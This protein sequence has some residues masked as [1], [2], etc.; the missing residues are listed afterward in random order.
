M[1]TSVLFVS[2]DNVLLGAT[3]SLLDLAVGL[4]QQGIEV[5]VVFPARGPASVR[6]KELGVT[7]DIVP[8][9]T[10]VTYYQ[11]L[12]IVY[13][14]IRRLK[15]RR[16]YKQLA[17]YISS[18]H[19]KFIYLNTQTLY[20]LLPFID[21][22]RTLILHIR[23]FG[24]ADHRM[25]YLHSGAY[26]KKCLHRA[27]ILLFNSNA[28]KDALVSQY[29]VAGKVV[30][31]GVMTVAEMEHALIDYHNALKERAAVNSLTIGV[32]GALNP[33]KGQEVVI[34]AVK[35]LYDRGCECRLLI[36]GDGKMRVEL[37]ALVRQLGLEEVVVFTGR[38][39]NPYNY[40][41]Q[42]DVL[43]HLA[44]C[45]AFGRVII[46]A[47]AYGIPVVARNAGGLPELIV[48]ERTGLLCDNN[49]QELATT[50]EAL[51]YN[52][53]LRKELGVAGHEACKINFS[54]ENY[55]SNFLNVLTT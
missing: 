21:E 18:S 8:Y 25:I 42:M 36:V 20:A 4:Q 11:P 9:L 16:L 37:E 5:K 3:R 40:Y 41:L 10:S 46:E 12:S 29:G 17:Q 39:D 1:M 44:E 33:T 38:V 28:V 6:C 14:I 26:V 51:Y 15:I 34:R 2:H 13:R 49:I 50:L 19:Y 22:K 35:E 32:V 55:I 47:Q 7:F 52:R 23:E 53:G 45:E 30:Y 48:H 54:S 27:S 24:Y 31:N 43:V